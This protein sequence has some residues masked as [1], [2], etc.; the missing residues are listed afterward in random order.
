MRLNNL[1]ITFSIINILPIRME[2]DLDRLV[3]LLFNKEIQP[4]KSVQLSGDFT[5]PQD[6]FEA[7]LML[8]TKGM[9]ILYAVDGV[10]PLGDLSQEQF[11]AFITRFQAIG[12][13]PQVDKYHVYQY[14][15]LQGSDISQEIN[16]EWNSK[17]D[18]YPSEI[19]LASLANYQT[20]TSENIADYYFQFK[21]EN[22]YYILHFNLI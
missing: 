15:S 1:E 18:Q 12:V 14:L 5:S 13:K 11:Q 7:F 20:T 4:I 22:H 3:D 21:S 19:P 17:K 16:D 10:V 2:G 9:R 8:F 6:L